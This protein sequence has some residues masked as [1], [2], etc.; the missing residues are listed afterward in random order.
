MYYSILVLMVRNLKNNIG[1]YPE[2]P[3][4]FLLGVIFRTL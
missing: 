4:H 3:L 2:A 1:N